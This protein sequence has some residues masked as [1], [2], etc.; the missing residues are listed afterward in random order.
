MRG[1][2]IMLVVKLVVSTLIVLTI[3]NLSMFIINVFHI[4]VEYP[5]I[6]ACIIGI[7]AAIPVWRW[8]DYES[9]EKYQWLVKMWGKIYK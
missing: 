6:F 5:E 9:L 4:S 7:A 2:Y 1:Y 3:G 8:I